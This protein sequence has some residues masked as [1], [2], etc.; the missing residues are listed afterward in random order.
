MAPTPW[1]F[2]SVIHGLDDGQSSKILDSCHRALPKSGRLLLVEPLIP[3]IPEAHPDHCSI[4]LSDLN[5]LA[6]GGSACERTEGEFRELLSKSGFRMT[7]AQPAGRYNVI[8][9]TVA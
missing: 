3:E 8:E 2:K 1:S 4:A 7:R 5:M 9:A 6:L